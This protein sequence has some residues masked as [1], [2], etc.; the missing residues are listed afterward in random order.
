MAKIVPFRGLR[1]N[2]DKI[3][4]LSRVVAPPYDAMTPAV[5]ERF[6]GRSPYNVANLVRRHEAESEKER[7]SHYGRAARE[8][9]KWR[10]QQVLVR[11]RHHVVYLCEQR[12]ENEEGDTV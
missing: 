9:E 1:F 12:Y 8:F 10:Q 3:S 2:P 4:D 11:E 6:C 5:Q 7:F